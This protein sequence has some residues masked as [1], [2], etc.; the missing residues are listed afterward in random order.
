ML[1]KLMNKA[2]V[3]VTSFA[4]LP[5]NAMHESESFHSPHSINRFNTFICFNFVWVALEFN[6]TA[7]ELGP[8][9][10]ADGVWKFIKSI[11]SP[12]CTRSPSTLPGKS[13]NTYRL[14]GSKLLLG[15]V[16]FPATATKTQLTKRGNTNPVLTNSFRSQR[17]IFLFF[18]SWPTLSAPI[19]QASRPNFL[20]F[21]SP[22]VI[23]SLPRWYALSL[24]D[25]N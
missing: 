13:D 5:E 10:R 15:N 14:I 7:C 3:I 19:G 22:F 11:T 6:A 2:H 24:S 1:W 16:C 12:N 25:R 23:Q 17:S 21:C 20:H 4:S 9:I 8:K 18:D